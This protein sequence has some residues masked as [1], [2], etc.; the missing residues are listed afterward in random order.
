ME[1]KIRGFQNPKTGSKAAPTAATRPLTPLSLSAK[2]YGPVLAVKGSAS[3]RFASWTAPVRAW[4]LAV[5][6]RKGGTATGGIPQDAVAQ[7][8]DSATIRPRAPRIRVFPPGAGQGGA[9]AFK[10]YQFTHS[11]SGSARLSA[12]SNTDHERHLSKSSSHFIAGEPGSN[13]GSRRTPSQG[14]WGGGPSTRVLILRFRKAARACKAVHRASEPSIPSPTPKLT[15]ETP[16]ASS[17]WK[18]GQRPP[19]SK[20]SHR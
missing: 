7:T 4:G 8:S 14:V 6:E 1:T 20:T 17:A 9:R 16:C 12:R 10:T 2:L 5:Y 15:R 13:P 18:Q 19:G 11:A 3:P